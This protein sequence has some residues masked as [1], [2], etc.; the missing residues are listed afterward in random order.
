MMVNCDGLLRLAIRNVNDKVDAAAIIAS[1]KI[2]RYGELV[3]H[4]M[5]APE[6]VMSWKSSATTA[7][8]V[9]Q[10]NIVLTVP[11]LPDIDHYVT[12]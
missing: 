1:N 5:R 3:G 4:L 8:I 7:I 12:G 9:D 2:A 11:V 6:P 10:R